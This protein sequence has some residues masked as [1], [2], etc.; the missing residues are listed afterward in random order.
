MF[1]AGL[2]L[3]PEGEDHLDGGGVAEGSEAHPRPPQRA[4]RG[5]PEEAPAVGAPESDHHGEQEDAPRHPEAD[6]GSNLL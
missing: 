2:H 1:L 3:R 4:L 6:P 5:V